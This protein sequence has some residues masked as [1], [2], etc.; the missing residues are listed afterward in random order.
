[1]SEAQCPGRGK[2]VP[3]KR[4]HS[5]SVLMGLAVTLALT[6]SFIT[7][8]LAHVPSQ[9]VAGHVAYRTSEA[10]K[11]PAAGITAA[12]CSLCVVAT[13]PV[14]TTPRGVAYDTANGYLYV[15]VA[16]NDV[17]VIDTTTYAL[18]AQISA[19]TGGNLEGAAYDSANGNVYVANYAQNE[20]FVIHGLS[21][22]ATVPVGS[23]PVG[24]TVDTTSGN[25]Y[26]ANNWGGSLS[27]INGTTN[28]LI[29][30]FSAGS[31]PFEMAFDS[32]NGY[33][34]VTDNSVGADV[35]SVVNPSTSTVIATITV[36]A[37]PQGITFDPQNGNIYVSDFKSNNLTIINGATNKV[38]GTI[39]LGPEPFE[40]AYSPFTQN[41]DVAGYGS[42]QT[43]VVT[44]GNGTVADSFPIGI[45]P[46]GVTPNPFN[47]S[48]Y[49]SNSGSSS[50]SVI[51]P[52]TPPVM[53][54]S[55]GETPASGV[56]PLN[57]QF[58]AQASAG[59]APYNFSW[60][61]GD[62]GTGSGGSVQHLYTSPGTYAVSLI[63]TDSVGQTAQ[64]NS[65]V[66][67]YPRPA[68]G[69]GAL[70]L[71]IAATPVTGP[72]PLATTFFASVTGGVGPYTYI[73]DFGV[74]Y[75]VSSGPT[76][77]YTYT[78][79]GEYVASVLVTDS[80][81]NQS[82]TGVF[83]TVGGGSS[84]SSVLVT[85]A[86]LQMRTQAPGTVTMIPSVVGGT[87]PYTLA[88]NFGDGSA[89]V[90]EQG[91]APE[92]HV[93]SK[94]GAYQPQV[95]VT[96]A[97]G[98][99]YLWKMGQNGPSAFVTVVS[100]PTQQ[101]NSSP[102]TEW[103][104]VLV[105]VVVAVVVVVLVASRMRKHPPEPNSNAMNGSAGSSQWHLP[106]PPTPPGEGPADPRMSNRPAVTHEDPLGNLL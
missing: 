59:T 35:V 37:N 72:A 24:V 52:V 38:S 14:G 98:A 99:T 105:V 79:S 68:N 84:P 51:A 13:L 101:T 27:E 28:A 36:G 25:I 16:T 67:V 23:S 39:P 55:V 29:S 17:T 1:M 62:G 60:T 44:P 6:I 32:S 21:I 104:I 80:A 93:Y 78:A 94:L 50:V 11:S 46:W 63:G 75:S 12:P 45:Q 83:I 57:V 48:F 91:T 42:N 76:A 102:L 70:E 56:A 88:W 5:F 33:L 64:A 82:S 95:Q 66:T 3:A 100:G 7:V 47:Q 10:G 69:S 81:G 103:M 4:A 8:G 22:I 2:F 26:V 85:V 86:V 41:L 87:G 58:T 90:T 9:P 77:S 40:V 71:S 65:T 15:A 30:T 54:V 19:G 73:W 96:D 61:F 74:G 31:F 53:S 97:H 49:V 92:S 18:V 43:M 34:Y 89:V 106:P 20:V